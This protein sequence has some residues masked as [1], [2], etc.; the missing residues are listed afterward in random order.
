MDSQAKY[1]VLA[2]GKGELYL[3]LQDELAV[4]SPLREQVDAALERLR[5][6]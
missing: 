6:S 2:V 3:R 1:I 4:D 5:G